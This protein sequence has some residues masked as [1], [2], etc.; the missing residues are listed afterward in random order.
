MICLELQSSGGRVW[1]VY[2]LWNWATWQ[3]NYWKVTCWRLSVSSQIWGNTLI[4]LR[5][6][7]SYGSDSPLTGPPQGNGFPKYLP[8]GG[9][10][11]WVLKTI[12]PMVGFLIAVQWPWIEQHDTRIFWGILR[13]WFSWGDLCGLHVAAALCLRESILVVMDDGV[14]SWKKGVG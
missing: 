12:S 3:F 2:T 14:P 10:I 4:R 1:N 5:T 9:R 7:R 6:I 11:W 13:I 8:R